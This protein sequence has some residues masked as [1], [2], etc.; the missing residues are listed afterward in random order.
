[1][2]IYIYFSISHVG[3]AKATFAELEDSVD[4]LEQ[5]LP[6]Q[7]GID[8]ETQIEEGE[9]FDFDVECE[10][11]LEVWR[12]GGTTQTFWDTFKNLLRIFK[13][14]WR[15]WTQIARAQLSAARVLLVFSSCS[16]RAAAT[17]GPRGQDPR[18]EHDGGPR[19][20]RTRLSAEAISTPNRKKKDTNTFYQH[21]LS[22]LFH[23]I[24]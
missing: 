22:Q 1:M 24:P 8:I 4:C 5:R 17:A 11:V 20:R 3:W 12:C 2:C 19:R 21:I 9:L 10:P 14:L 13:T 16:A 15:C 18:A 6:V 7:I 23:T